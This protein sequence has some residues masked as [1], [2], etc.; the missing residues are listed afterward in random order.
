MV[1]KYYIMPQVGTG[2]APNRELQPGEDFAIRPKYQPE[3]RA[4]HPTSWVNKIGRIYA[5]IDA[6]PAVLSFLDRQADVIDL[7]DTPA[8]AREAIKSRLPFDQDMQEVRRRFNTDAVLDYLLRIRRTRIRRTPGTDTTTWNNNDGTAWTA[9]TAFALTKVDI[10]GTPGFITIDVLT[11][12]G[13]IHHP[14]GGGFDTEETIWHQ[15]GDSAEDCTELCA[16]VAVC[17]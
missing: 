16:E 6:D 2:R 8:L 15:T 7:G 3:I 5:F 4:I 13:R 14:G 11:N 17:L 9:L 12:Q 1:T 10:S